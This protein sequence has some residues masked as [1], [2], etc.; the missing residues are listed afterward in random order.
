MYMCLSLLHTRVQTEGGGGEGGVGSKKKGRVG[1]EAG[2]GRK[3]E[4]KGGVGEDGGKKTG[5]QR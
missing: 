5:E 2:Q 3:G 4:G 1:G